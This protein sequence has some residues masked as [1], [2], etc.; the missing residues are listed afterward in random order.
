MSGGPS[1]SC[2]L[3]L[4]R[5]RLRSLPHLSQIPPESPCARCES[6]RGRLPPDASIGVRADTPAQRASRGTVC[7]LPRR[8]HSDHCLLRSAQRRRRRS[9][10]RFRLHP[11]SKASSVPRIVSRSSLASMRASRRSS[12]VSS[13]ATRCSSLASNRAKLSSFNSA[14]L[15]AVARVDLVEIAHQ[16][17]RECVSAESIPLPV[18]SSYRMQYGL[19]PRAAGRLRACRKSPPS[20]LASWPRP[21]CPRILR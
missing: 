6:T 20:A 14:Q 9:C 21:V 10:L 11:L 12:F 15:G 19:L 5:A 2:C 13:C 1:Q 7:G 16:L 18:T 8:V 4:S 3:V 17:V